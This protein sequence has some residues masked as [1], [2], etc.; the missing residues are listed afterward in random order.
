MLTLPIILPD[1][2]SIIDALLA[3]FG[4]MVVA[5]LARFLVG[6]VTG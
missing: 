2:V 1:G 6:F 3:I 4:A 5:L